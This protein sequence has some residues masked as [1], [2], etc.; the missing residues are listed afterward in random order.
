[1]DLAHGERDDDAE[2]ADEEPAPG[3]RHGA[4]PLKR[5]V[6]RRQAARED[7][8]DRERDREVR[9]AAHLAVEHL[10]VAELVEQAL[11]VVR[12]YRWCF[13]AHPSSLIVRTR[14]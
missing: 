12:L 7:R 4:A 1:R 13:R 9:E 10:R 6:V 8:D 3:D 5:D 11:I 2:A 14:T